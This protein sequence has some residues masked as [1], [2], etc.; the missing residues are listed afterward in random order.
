M[1][2]FFTEP[3]PDELIYSAIARYHFYSGNIDC[4]DTLEEVFQSRNVIPS[5]EIG[6]HFNILSQQ[7]GAN[8]SVDGLLAKHTIYPFYAPFLSKKRQQEVFQDVQDDGKALYTRLGFVA[9]SICKKNGLYYCPQCAKS[10]LDRYGEPYI[11]REHHLQGIDI[12]AHHE[13]LLKKYPVDFSIQSRIEFVR[14]EAK[15]INFSVLQEVE[16][17]EYF[18]IQVQLAKMAYQLL[19]IT[20]LS[21][22]IIN[23]KYHS[24]LRERNL[25]TVS[26]RVRQAEL[27]QAFHSK[28][29]TGLLEKYDSA[30]NVAD[31]YNWLKVITRNSI[32]H[33]HPF[34]HL[35]FLYYLD[36]DVQQLFLVKE[37][38]VPFGKGPWPCLN[39]AAIH[40]KQH[41]ISGVTVTRDFKSDAPIGT[42]KC[43]C[44]FIYARKGPDKLVEDKYR[45]GRIK[46]FGDVWKDKVRTLANEGE[47]STRAM[48][49][50]LGV[51]S[52]TVKKYLNV[53]EQEGKVLN[54]NHSLLL[55]QHKE[56]LFVGIQQYPEYTRTQI[57]KR[58]PKQY[59]YLY[60]HDKE[61][62]FE[63]LPESCKNVISNVV[64]D[65]SKRDDEYYEKVKQLYKELI[66]LEKPIRITNSI[67]GKR[68]EILANLDKHIDKIPRT[69]ELL[70][71]IKESTQQFQ[72]RRCCKIIDR[73]FQEKEPIEL[74]KV[75]RIGAVKSHHFHEIKSHLEAHIRMKREVENYEQTTG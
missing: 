36:L 73:M 24:L 6:S 10:D 44:G 14:F 50:I 35:L 60:R 55:N 67:I 37:N 59:M 63:Q 5:I 74:W 57:R 19:H 75:Q 4:K 51:D 28:F 54:I 66:A 1:L 39:K 52:K 12:C 71:D 13:L 21:R 72:I 3:Y 7:M 68:L 65:W 25:I 8:Y 46:V 64:V 38:R 40:Y 41:V 61:W 48:A 18:E 49:K 29:P 11:H 47:L 22:E 56:Q 31:E 15:R 26:N 17:Y 70:N 43:S 20:T 69:R 45:I 9:G 23:Q 58:F 27:Y 34:R 16:S 62:L 42:F 33:V 2:P 30:I 32:R 53:H